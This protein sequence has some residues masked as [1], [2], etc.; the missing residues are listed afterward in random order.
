MLRRW[1]VP[2]VIQHRKSDKDCFQKV[3]KMR[4][5][6]DMFGFESKEEDTRLVAELISILAKEEQMTTSRA[7][8]ILSDVQRLFPLISII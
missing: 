7:S 1:K 6:L 2:A 8:G 3:L 5:D 4:Q